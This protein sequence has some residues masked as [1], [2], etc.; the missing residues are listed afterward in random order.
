MSAP[1][2]GG[3]LKLVTSTY[4]KVKGGLYTYNTNIGIGLSATSDFNEIEGAEITHNGSYGLLGGTAAD[5][6]FNKHN[7]YVANTVEYNADDGL[8]VDHNP[9]CV[10]IGNRVRYNGT[11]GSDDGL[12]VDTS[13]RSVISGNRVE[14]NAGHGIQ[15][16]N[17]S[18]YCSVTD[19]VVGDNSSPAVGGPA[20]GVGII[21]EAGITYCSVTGNT[22]FCTEVTPSQRRGIYLTGIGVDY[23]VVTSNTVYGNS[24]NQIELSSNVG[25]NNAVYA[26]PG[27]NLGNTNTLFSRLADAPIR[28]TNSISSTSAIEITQTGNTSGSSTGSA[29][30]KV[31]NTSNTGY[32]FSVYTDMG[33]G[34]AAA[35]VVIH[36]DNSTGLWDFSIGLAR[37]I[38]DT[39]H[40][41]IQLEQNAAPNAS[42]AAL[43]VTSSSNNSTANAYGLLAIIQSNA[44]T[45]NRGLWIDHGGTGEGAQIRSTGGG[46]NL[47]LTQ[48]G[49]NLSLDAFKSLTN[50]T[51]STT[52]VSIISN[53]TVSDG[54]SYSNTG[55]AFVVSSNAT[56]T[57]GSI[58]NS[59]KLATFTQSDTSATGNLM[60]IVNAG[61]GKALWIDNNNTGLSLDID[62]DANSASSI[63]GVFLDVDNAGAGG[64][65]GWDISTVTSGAG[66]SNPA[67]G[68]RIAMPTG[69]SAN[70]ALQLSNTG[71]TPA[72]GITFGT[73]VQ[74][75]RSAANVL[76]LASGDSLGIAERYHPWHCHRHEDWHGHEPKAR[77]LQCDA[78]R[79]TVGI[80]ADLFHG[81]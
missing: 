18:H 72:G 56:R 27:A 71:G 28:V 38:N 67:I 21:L 59:A 29:A 52:G 45:T 47:I 30:L 75:Y 13:P 26:N 50:R 2:V 46:R 5:T 63:T 48:S 9:D 66:S 17:G 81:G 33:A 7:R 1:P 44:N 36:N 4:C 61:T 22:V 57:S 15:L 24:V 16:K 62:H 11:G 54:N 37:F 78:G 3:G 74:L 40:N 64:A 49:N 60:E 80:Y 35:P 23:N 6:S 69:G 53:V 68:L 41:G 19:N 79:P 77:L 20:T 51:N 58:T 55:T 76:S 65:I 34:A 14:F 25:D 42:R 10:C 70:Y 12:P 8:V 39:N 73:D 32:G 43:L 31:I